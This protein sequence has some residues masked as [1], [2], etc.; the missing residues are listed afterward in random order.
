[1]PTSASNFFRILAKIA[2]AVMTVMSLLLMQPTHAHAAV[3]VAA[4]CSADSN[5]FQSSGFEA[6]AQTFRVKRD[7][8]LT[9]AQVTVNGVGDFVLE[10]RPV[11]KSGAPS[12]RVLASTTV[13]NSSASPATITGRFDTPVHV[14]AQKP[15]ALVVTLPDDHHGAQV[16][17]E[18]PCPGSVYL[19]QAGETK[20]GQSGT[21]GVDL[22]FA[23]YMK[24]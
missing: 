8:A 2:A 21:P 18:D 17:T 3:S 13:S 15:Y 24:K 9:R 19:R 10:I 11:K 20:F 6:L 7:S 23:V 14:K 16:A 4:S 5:V 12:Q 1:M 22:T